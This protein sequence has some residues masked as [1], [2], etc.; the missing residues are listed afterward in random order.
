MLSILLNLKT[1]WHLL[2]CALLLGAI[3]LQFYQHKSDR[4]FILQ[5]NKDLALCR[6]SI[7]VQN[8][9]VEQ[10]KAQSVAENRGQ[11][12]RDKEA[13]KR[14][15]QQTQG[16]SSILN[17]PIPSDCMGAFLYGINHR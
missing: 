6:S 10:W 4:A 9:A 3:A 7:E 1:N 13:S 17:A 12:L 15:V 11:L 2:L 5:Q 14:L 16:V 8:K